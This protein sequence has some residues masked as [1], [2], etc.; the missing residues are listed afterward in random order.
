VF[1]CAQRTGDPPWIQKVRS[2]TL[3]EEERKEIPVTAVL[4][5]KVVCVLSGAMFLAHVLDR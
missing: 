1:R 4:V 2:K 5:Y 3:A